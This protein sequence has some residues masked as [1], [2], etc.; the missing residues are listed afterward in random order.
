M[1]S[2]K[3]MGNTTPHRG[4]GLPGWDGQESGRGRPAGKGQTDATAPGFMAKPAIGYEA[5]SAKGL[6]TSRRASAGAGLSSAWCAEPGAAVERCHNKMRVTTATPE[7]TR[8][9]SDERALAEARCPNSVPF[10]ERPCASVG[11]SPAKSLVERAGCGWRWVEQPLVTSSE[12]LDAHPVGGG[13]GCRHQVGHA[14]EDPT[15]R[16]FP[17]YP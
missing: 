17:V 12:G 2:P 3:K 1:C 16:R 6:E 7:A 13:Q 11:H 9:R 14:A 10:G 8:E 5:A 4:G 15:T